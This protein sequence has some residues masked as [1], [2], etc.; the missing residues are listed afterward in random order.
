MKPD[1]ND[2]V[3]SLLV[4]FFL[5]FL[6]PGIIFTD[7]LVRYEFGF[8]FWYITVYQ[9]E[10]GSVWLGNNFF[11]GNAGLSINPLFFLFNVMIMYFVIHRIRKRPNKRRKTEK[12]VVK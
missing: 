5:S 6:I 7:G 11:A 12:E 1:Q 9:T 8:P 3:L 10:A 4:C 2:I